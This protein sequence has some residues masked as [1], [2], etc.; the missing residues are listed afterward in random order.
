MLNGL[1]RALRRLLAGICL[2]SPTPPSAS[3]RGTRAGPRVARARW[4]IRR[5]PD[6][7]IQV[8]SERRSGSER[9]DPAVPRRDANRCEI[10]IQRFLELG[11]RPLCAHS[12]RPR[13]TRDHRGWVALRFQGV[14]SSPHSVLKAPRI[15]VNSRTSLIA[16]PRRTVLFCREFP[17]QTLPQVLLAMQKVEGSNP[18]SRSRL[19]YRSP[20]TRGIRRAGRTRK[21]CQPTR[22]VRPLPASRRARVGSPA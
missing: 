1:G 7:S 20:M 9:R 4:A 8:T 11:H 2:R 22:R 5:D 19:P 17:A 3:S 14:G 13:L 10:G 16:H 21:P 12:A 6:G 18:F 15:R